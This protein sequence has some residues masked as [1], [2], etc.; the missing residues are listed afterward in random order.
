VADCTPA[1]H[2][3]VLHEESQV[4]PVALTALK[5]ACQVSPLEVLLILGTLMVMVLLAY[6]GV[7][8]LPAGKLLMLRV[9]LLSQNAALLSVI[10][11][12]AQ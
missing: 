6:V 2:H 10:V 9:E 4:Q 11:T 3:T 8:A 5:L 1:L 7:G 12:S